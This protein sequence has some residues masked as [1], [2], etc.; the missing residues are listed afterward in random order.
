MPSDVIQCGG[1]SDIE[2]TQDML[3][4]EAHESEVGAAFIDHFV[5]SVQLSAPLYIRCH[6]DGDCF[7]RLVTAQEGEGIAYDSPA[8]GATKYQRPTDWIN[9]INV[10]NFASIHHKLTAVHVLYCT[11]YL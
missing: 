11:M 1:C 6:G 10:I 5:A 8:L 2:P 4:V 3:T 7:R 9:A